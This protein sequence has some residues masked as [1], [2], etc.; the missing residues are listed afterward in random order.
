MIAPI[1]GDKMN[2]HTCSRA[3]PPK[4]NAGAK[5]RAGL[6]DV[7]VNGIPMI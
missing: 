3:C 1:I 5:L 2:T 7:P 4:N 6:T